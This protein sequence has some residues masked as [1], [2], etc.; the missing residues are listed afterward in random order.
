M[1]LEKKIGTGFENLHKTTD[2]TLFDS[3]NT[4]FAIDHKKLV[5]SYGL[6]LYSST[7]NSGNAG[8]KI[9][10]STT[11]RTTYK[12][13]AGQ[14][15]DGMEY[16]LQSQGSSIPEGISYIIS[17]NKTNFEI[18]VSLKREKNSGQFDRISRIV[19]PVGFMGD[20]VMFTLNRQTGGIVAKL[21]D[22][23]F[24]SA[25]NPDGGLNKWH[26]VHIKASGPGDGR[27]YFV[28]SDHPDPNPASNNIS[29][30]VNGSYLP[31]IILESADEVSG[32]GRDTMYVDD[33]T[34]WEDTDDVNAKNVIEA[35]GN[36]ND[37]FQKHVRYTLPRTSAFEAFSN[38]AFNWTTLTG[39][40]QGAGNMWSDIAINYGALGNDRKLIKDGELGWDLDNFSLGSTFNTQQ[41]LSS[42]A[43]LDKIVSI[44]FTLPRAFNDGTAPFT[45][46]GRINN[47][48]KNITINTGDDNHGY[49]RF[50]ESDL[51][52]ANVDKNTNSANFVATI[53]K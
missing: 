27:I 7:G 43:S 42:P 28:A 30:D 46:K 50:E 3:T 1:A 34:I 20:E 19:I 52:N 35:I 12:H 47:V 48:Q 32:L 11:A 13:A 49:V 18:S 29:F 8:N 10:E 24:L 39:F 51:A 6:D 38:S 41:H 37:S 25:S 4:L 36:G 26:D 53:F 44:A 33:I 9:Q 31:E 5:E 23:S 15:I 16:K 17:T 2:G 45:I 14:D 22:G 21:P 40:Q